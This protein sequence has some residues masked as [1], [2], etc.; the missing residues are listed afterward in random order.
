MTIKAPYFF[1]FWYKFIL[2]HYTFVYIDIYIFLS[3]L[4]A[5]KIGEKVYEGKGARDT[6]MKR[7]SR[8]KAMYT[9]V[10]CGSADVTYLPPITVKQ[11][12]NNCAEWEIGGPNGLAMDFLQKVGCSTSTLKSGSPPSSLRTM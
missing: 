1:L 8:G 6:Y 9:V 7:S 10:F 5:K 12:P 2:E 11:G 4:T 3:G